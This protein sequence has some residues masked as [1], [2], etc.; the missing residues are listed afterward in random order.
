M[1]LLG[2]PVHLTP[3]IAKCTAAETYC[4]VIED[5]KRV[6]HCPRLDNHRAVLWKRAWT[7]AVYISVQQRTQTG[8]LQRT[9][10]AMQ[11]CLNSH[12]ALLRNP[13]GSNHNCKTCKQC[14]N[15]PQ[16][17]SPDPSANDRCGTIRIAM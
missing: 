10:Q 6:L 15:H 11:R 14:I 17:L 13:R 3:R 16:R 2:Q 12:I 8:P 5:D 7:P 9:G 1:T 4:D